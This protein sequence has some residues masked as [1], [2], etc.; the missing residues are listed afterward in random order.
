MNIIFVLTIHL[1]VESK[2]MYELQDVFSYQ[3]ICILHNNFE[4]K[5]NI[6]LCINC[7]TFY[8]EKGCTI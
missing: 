7:V 8:D 2:L 6:A 5:N 3:G 1:E 4:K